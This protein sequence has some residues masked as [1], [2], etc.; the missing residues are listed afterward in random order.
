MCG[1]LCNPGVD[2]VQTLFGRH[3]PQEFEVVEVVGPEFTVRGVVPVNFGQGGKRDF[4][5]QE[6]EA[7][8]VFALLFY[9]PLHLRSRRIILR[10]LTRSP[11][12]KL[13]GYLP[14]AEVA[15]G[16]EEAK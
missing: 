15:K 4:K 5:V 2:V 14:G 13:I 12:V 7:D 3:D 8:G 11:V 16:M 9:L 6:D 1:F 10:Q